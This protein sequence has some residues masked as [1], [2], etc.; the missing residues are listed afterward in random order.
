MY[1]SILH[2]SSRCDFKL[3]HY[4]FSFPET[5]ITGFRGTQSYHSQ[6]ERSDSLD[7]IIN[8]LIVLSESDFIV[9]GFSSNVSDFTQTQI[10]AQDIPT[11]YGKH[12]DDSIEYITYMNF[13]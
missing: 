12:T 11:P 7:G 2:Q 4:F 10:H 1:P 8:D 5:H 3:L 13:F 6:A 9:C